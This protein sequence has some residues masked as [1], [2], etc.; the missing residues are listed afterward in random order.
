LALGDPMRKNKGATGEGMPPRSR[1]ARSFLSLLSACVALAAAGCSAGDVELN[2]GVFD[3]VGIGSNSVK[4]TSDPKLA[5]RAPL[6]VPPALDRLPAP[7]SE[8]APP[9]EIAGIKDPDAAKAKSREELEKQQAEFCAK[10]YD[11]ARMRGEE[12]DM[13]AGPLG[14]CRKSVLTA[15]QQ[16]NKAE[17]EAAGQ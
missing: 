1:P 15:I 11:D 9:A 8:P 14:P 17:D 5:E 16:W 6:V 3:A 13:V 2:G 10:N 7:G 12:A 4:K